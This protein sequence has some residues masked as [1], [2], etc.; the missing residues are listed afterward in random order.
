MQNLLTLR[1][2]FMLRLHGFLIITFIMSLEK[3]NLYIY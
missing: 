1:N 2:V 3:Q